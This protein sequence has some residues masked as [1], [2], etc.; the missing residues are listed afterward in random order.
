MNKKNVGIRRNA[1]PEWKY[2]L[3]FVGPAVLYICIFALY[4][5]IYNFYLA[6]RNMTARHF[7]NHT[8]VGLE[9]F[10]ELFSKGVLSTTIGNTIWYTVWCTILQFIIGF[11]FALLLSKNFPLAQ[12]IRGTLLVGWLLPMTVTAILFKFMFQTDIGIINYL[13]G[14]VGISPIEWLTNGTNAM[15]ALIIA[16]TWV[17]IPFD[18]VLL[19]TGLSGIGPE[20]YE[21][22]QIDGANRIQSFFH[23]TIPLLKSTIYSICILG[24]IYTF[25]VFDVVVVMTMGGPVDSTEVMSTYSY[26]LAFKEFNFSEGSA[27]ACI[28][29]VILFLAGLI[30]LRFIK[31]DEV[32]N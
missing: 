26:K 31:E 28:L 7:L 12:G 5:V 14:A 11:A 18:M 1:N 32:M 20:M 4:P 25:K 30:Y 22:A 23:I 2:S 15:W 21:S 10:Q 27:V 24:V 19:S 13:L 6:F 9:T 16:N 17:G 3:L 29:F 8:F